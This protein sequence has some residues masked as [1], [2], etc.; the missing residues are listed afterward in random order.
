[1]SAAPDIP[2]EATWTAFVHR[3]AAVAG[4]AVGLVA[5]IA[6][7][8]AQIASLR[9]ALAWCAALVLG[10]GARWLVQRTA[11]PPAEPLPHEELAEVEND[12][13]LKPSEAAGR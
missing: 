3:A 4:A 10:R 7:A 11:P 9:G 8:P 5:L 12:S 2:L 6:G 13:T 1:M